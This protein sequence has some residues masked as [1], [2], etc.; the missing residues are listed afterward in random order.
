MIKVEFTRNVIGHK[1]GDVMEYPD[2]DSGLIR[3]WI[4]DG[5]CRKVTDEKAKTEKDK[6]KPKEKVE[7]INPKPAEKVKTNVP[8]RTTKKK[9][10]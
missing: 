9:I 1:V 10:K 8:P 6:R 4:A 3:A 5:R 2:K 7:R